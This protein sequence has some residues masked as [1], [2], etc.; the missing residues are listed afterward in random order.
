MRNRLTVLN[1]LHDASLCFLHQ[2]PSVEERKTVDD[3]DS[4]EEDSD[5]EEDD[6]IS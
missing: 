1:H 4:D 3:G 6:V 5:E 2:A